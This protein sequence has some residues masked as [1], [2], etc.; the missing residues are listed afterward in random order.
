MFAVS[1]LPGQ[2]TKNPET[3][4]ETQTRATDRF[5]GLL[6]R[7]GGGSWL[8]SGGWW[9]CSVLA[10]W[11][12]GVPGALVLSGARAPAGLQVT[13]TRGPVWPCP[14]S[15]SNL[16]RG[17]SGACGFRGAVP[18]VLLGPCRG[19]CGLRRAPMAPTRYAVTD[20]PLRRHLRGPWSRLFS[21]STPCCLTLYFSCG[22]APGPVKGPGA[23]C[24]GFNLSRCPLS[25]DTPWAVVAAVLAQHTLLLDV[26]LLLRRRPRAGEGPRGALCWV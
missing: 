8:G 1:P 16:V 9:P 20:R 15:L 22:G 6:C 2:E 4:T 19:L 3:H 11:G 17:P 14:G 18:A 25:V 12:F 10:G 26:V 13:L 21:P 7:G 5:L 24:A 23:P